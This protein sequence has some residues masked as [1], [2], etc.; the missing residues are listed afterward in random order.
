M[1]A[2]YPVFHNG[3]NFFAP[4]AAVENAI[5]ADFW[6]H[7]ILFERRRQAGRN[8]QRG[9]CLAQS[10]DIIA[11]TLNRQQADIGDRSRINQLTAI[12]EFALRQQMALEHRVNGGY[13]DSALN[14]CTLEFR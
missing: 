4:F 13:G 6:R 10:A 7:M 12:V 14:Y 2:G 9:L 8:I 1:V 3:R 5:M 11:L